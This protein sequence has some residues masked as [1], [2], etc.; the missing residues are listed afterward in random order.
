MLLLK[1]KFEFWFNPILFWGLLLKPY[2]NKFLP[3][4]GSLK[5]FP[6]FWFPENNPVFILFWI[7]FGLFKELLKSK[8]VLGCYKLSILLLLLVLLLFIFLL[9]KIEFEEFKLLAKLFENKF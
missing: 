6:E 7:G 4:L 5:E 3:K 8:L 9:L 1:E 2:E